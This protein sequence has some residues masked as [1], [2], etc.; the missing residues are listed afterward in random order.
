MEAFSRQLAAQ[1]LRAVH[2]RLETVRQ[3][4]Q[5]ENQARAWQARQ[6]KK[7]ASEGP[8]QGDKKMR[9]EATNDGNEEEGE[10][11]VGAELREL[12]AKWRAASRLAAEE[13]YE[14]IK[15]RVESMGGAKAWRES[16]RWQARGGNWGFRDNG[17]DGEAKTRACAVEDDEVGRYE[18][19]KEGQAD[20]GNEKLEDEDGEV[21]LYGMG[22]GDMN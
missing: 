22:C 1:H 9:K 7:I 3:A 20:Q 5:I 6:R 17:N 12:T 10:L 19:Y 15:G 18:A 2:Q 14:L 8:Q 21:S 16:R 4:R 13:L 11:D